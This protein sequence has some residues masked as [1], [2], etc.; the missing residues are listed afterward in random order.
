MKGDGDGLLKLFTPSCF[1]WGAERGGNAG[2]WV[3]KE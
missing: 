3:E 2:W 1:C